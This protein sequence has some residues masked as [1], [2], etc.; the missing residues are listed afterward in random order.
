MNQY[1]FAMHPTVVYGA[2]SLATLA[3]HV[4]ALGKHKALIVTDT[5]LGKTGIPQRV[6]AVLPGSVLYD[7]VTPDPHLEDVHAALDALRGHEADVLVA[8]GGGSSID[9]A[10]LAAILET[11]G[12]DLLEY[13]AHWDHIQTPGIPLIAIPTTVGSGSE[14]TRGAVFSSPVTKGKAVIVSKHLAARLAILDPTLL[15]TLPA[16]V[17][18]STGADALTQAIEGVLSTAATPFTD[19]LHLEAIR[20]VRSALR[21]AV[22]NSKDAQ[23]MG[24]MQQGA[25]M[26]GAGIA[27]SG[28]GAVHAIANTLGGHYSIPHGVAC[29]IMLRPVLRFNA[30]HALERY[31]L[32]ADALALN[33]RELSAAQVADAVTAEVSGIL[34]DIGVTWRLREFKMPEADIEQVAEESRVHADMGSNP[35]QPTVSEIETLLREVW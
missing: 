13:A 21:A 23:A 16:A 34:D 3:D 10:K 27:Y 18:A 9:V 28:V 4:R 25:A 11:N 32:L 1:T 8:V 24:T 5:T 35:Y 14:M 7:G 15:D 17:T 2:G 6:Q 31:R 26:A 22:A 29:A 33:V 12:G 20:L 19:A 30:P